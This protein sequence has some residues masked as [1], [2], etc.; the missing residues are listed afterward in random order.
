MA[1]AEGRGSIKFTLDDGTVLTIALGDDS[2]EDAQGRVFAV[3]WAQDE[4]GRLQVGAGLDW[5]P[6][7]GGTAAHGRRG[8]S[9]FRTGA[10]RPSPPPALPIPLPNR[11]AN[12]FLQVLR[13]DP[14]EKTESSVSASE[15]APRPT[16]DGVEGLRQRT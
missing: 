2:V 15:A 4:Q 1:E 9:S 7:L 14:M 13:C 16:V 12:H 5:G 8:P 10:A 11:A 6:A 3:V